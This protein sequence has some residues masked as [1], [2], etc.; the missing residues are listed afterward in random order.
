MKG[1]RLTLIPQRAGFY[2]VVTV[3]TAEPLLSEGALAIFS[4]MEGEQ[5]ALFETPASAMSWALALGDQKLQTQIGVDNGAVLQLKVS[6]SSSFLGSPVDWS[7]ALARA[8]NPGQLLISKE[9]WSLL[10]R[11]GEELGFFASSLGVCRFANA[12]RTGEVYD[13][14]TNT[15]VARTHSPLDA[16]TCVTN[17]SGKAQVFVGRD[18]EFGEIDE[19]FERGVA[20]VSVVGPGGIGKSRLVQRFAGVRACQ[21]DRVIVCNMRLVHTLERFQ[22][23]VATALGVPL[24]THGI[25]AIAQLGNAF[26]AAKR[27]LLVL[28]SVE[29]G[30]RFLKM[31]VG[32]WIQDAPNLRVLATTRERLE[33]EDERTLFLEPLP[34]DAAVALF[35]LEAAV[36]NDGFDFESDVV[37]QIERIVARV[38]GVPLA[39]EL[40]A[41]WTDILTPGQ[42][43]HKLSDSLELLSQPSQEGQD[44]ITSMMVFSWEQMAPWER[45]IFVS[46]AVFHGSFSADAAAAVV[47]LDAFPGAPDFSEVLRSLRNKSLIY[48][49]D[50]VGDVA[51]YRMFDVVSAYAK[52]RLA[53]SGLRATTE[54]LAIDWYVRLGEELAEAARSGDADAHEAIAQDLDNFTEVIR[55]TTDQRPHIAVAVLLA[56][57]PLLAVRG[58]Y[59]LWTQH[60]ATAHQLSQELSLQTQVRTTNA[61]ASA[62]LARGRSEE[63]LSFVKPVLGA[64][65]EA[66]ELAT[67]LRV[68]VVRIHRALGDMKAANHAAA[69]ALEEAKG[70]NYYGEAMAVAGDVRYA[71]GDLVMARKL[72]NQA[73]IR[74]QCPRK[75]AAVLAELGDICR[76][77]GDVPRAKDNYDEAHAT[78]RRLRDTPGVARILA[79]IG[80]MALDLKDYEGA[81]ARFTKAHALFL[82]VGDGHQAAIMTGNLGRVSHAK[83][84]SSEAERC[85]T[86]AISTL[87]E[88]GDRRFAAIFLGNLATVRHEVGNPK[89]QSDYE[90]AIASLEETGDRR[91][92]AIFLARLGALAADQNK[93]TEAAR[94]LDQAVSLV[95]RASDPM[96]ASAVALHYA[97]LAL[98]RSGK[99][100]IQAAKRAYY[101]GVGTQ[102][103]PGAAKNSHD[104]R[105]A[106]RML[107]ARLKQL[108][109]TP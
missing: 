97:H 43:T 12:E 90:S 16:L 73:A 100:G 48:A 46:L 33:L 68:R 24:R 91:F 58:P 82:E 22:Q 83:G 31:T 98:A 57:E 71:L 38:Q 45:A 108:E 47:Q 78:L 93:P 27:T 52:T 15:T 85:F 42:L 36:I 9:I 25:M 107:A 53:Q 101:E 103:S 44:S 8:A 56:I 11:A 88:V 50:S 94:H 4:P 32:S 3:R 13:V 63:A 65:E 21:Y 49:N 17:H 86:T 54:Q 6:E 87:E 79:K 35:S 66:E 7:R 104:V 84:A 76:I 67:A 18:K 74:Q 77:E 99:D 23:V 92:F 41:A 59:D 60:M 81:V 28:D 39:I 61:Y 69:Y 14:R 5:I 19:T 96:G 29:R 106:S 70:T 55:H 80:S 2:S 102:E 62:L 40:A 72:L 75:R 30:S 37:E 1:Y 51:R 26:I 20:V 89:A 105:L 64:C 34:P 95:K 109:R 10:T